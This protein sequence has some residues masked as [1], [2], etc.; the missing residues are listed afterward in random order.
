MRQQ[1]YIVVF[2]KGNKHETGVYLEYGW[3]KKGQAK[4]TAEKNG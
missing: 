3:M 1:Y 2:I 4:R